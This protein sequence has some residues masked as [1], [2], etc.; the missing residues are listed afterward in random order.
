MGESL[1]LHAHN[2]N[3]ANSYVQMFIS[4]KNKNLFLRKVYQRNIFKNYIYHKK[5]YVKNVLKLIEKCYHLN[6]IYV[7]L[8]HFSLRHDYKIFNS[9]LDLINCDDE[10]IYMH[11]N[12]RF[13]QFDTDNKKQ[14]YYYKY[15]KPYIPF[16]YGH[17]RYL[18][19]EQK[20]HYA[21]S[22][23]SLNFEPEGKHRKFIILSSQKVI[24]L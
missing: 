14:G 6:K 17:V 2:T 8:P 13:L 20:L 3:L 15:P 21:F 16:L 7:D 5:L 19:S 18:R 11:K 4:G 12:D 24:E 10:F 23:Y 22:P 1:F 9:N